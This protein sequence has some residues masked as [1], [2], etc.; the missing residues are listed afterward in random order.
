MP[1]PAT[2][3]PFL[4]LPLCIAPAAWAQSTAHDDGTAPPTE[5]DTVQVQAAHYQARRDDTAT[6]IVIDATQ[7]RQYGDPA[8]LD[9]LKRLPGI[10]VGQ[11][12]PGRSG[13]LSLRGLGAGYTQILING[14]KAPLGFDLDALSPEMVERVE[15]LRAPTAD[16]R[17][18]AI[19]GTLN[20]V[21]VAGARKEAESLA[22]AWGLSNARSAP[23]LTW[24]RSRRQAHRSQ[25]VAVSA[26][27]R[28]FPGGAAG[29]GNSVW[30]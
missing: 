1:L 19:A 28:A 9:A 10:S 16:Q 17:T 5:L 3:R 15:I 20:I 26:S 27:R 21:L 14:Q 18:E 23:S 29:P 13:T 25:S 22:L 6:R 4:L 8:L 7:L 2:C 11:G 12:A 24:Q 30:P